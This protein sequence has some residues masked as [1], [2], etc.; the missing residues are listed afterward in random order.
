M[1]IRLIGMTPAEV[2]R[3]RFAL[4]AL[5]RHVPKELAHVRRALQFIMMSPAPWAFDGSVRAH[6][7]LTIWGRGTMLIHRPSAMPIEDIAVSV[8]H[9]ARHIVLHP[10]GTFTLREHTF[11]RRTPTL[12]ERQADPIYARD[13][14]VHRILSA[15]LR[16]ERARARRL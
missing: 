6:T 16:R 12:E 7:A 11:G 15:G 9:E 14:E 3:V 4:D 1:G 10:S 13:D 5:D 2:S 8:T